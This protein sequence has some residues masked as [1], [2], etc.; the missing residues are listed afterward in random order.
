LYATKITGAVPFV[1][2]AFFAALV[3]LTFLYNNSAFKIKGFAN[4]GILFGN[5]EV[6]QT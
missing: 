5:G 3:F 2:G 6:N 4:S 1:N